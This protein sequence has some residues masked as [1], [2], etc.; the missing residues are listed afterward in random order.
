MWR[1]FANALKKADRSPLSIGESAS[2]H[3]ATVRAP[4]SDCA[5]YHQ[6]EGQAS[7]W[8]RASF[9]KVAGSSAEMQT[10]LSVNIRVARGCIAD[11]VTA[12]VASTMK[13]AHA[14]A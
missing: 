7:T 14:S 11:R 8:R 10:S 1:V 6:P 12:P 9:R 3:K 5:V 2:V 4:A 13:L